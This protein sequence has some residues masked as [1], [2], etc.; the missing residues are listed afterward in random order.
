VATDR[1]SRSNTVIEIIIKRLFLIT[2]FYN[3]LSFIDIACIKGS[4]AESI[5]FSRRY[6]PGSQAFGSHRASN[7]RIVWV[8]LFP[9][10]KRFA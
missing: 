7:L 9:N 6:F 3:V 2:P 8:G 1:E 4:A 10:A 5:C